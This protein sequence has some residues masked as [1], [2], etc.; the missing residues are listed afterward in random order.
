MFSCFI[1]F[2]LAHPFECKGVRMEGRVYFFSS[3]MRCTGACQ[4]IFF[5]FWQRWYL[6][7]RFVARIC[8]KNAKFSIFSIIEYV[9]L[10]FSFIK[11]L[12]KFSIFFQS[13]AI[14]GPF[15]KFRPASRALRG[16]FSN[17]GPLRGPFS[18]SGPLR[19]L[20]V[21]PVCRLRRQN[22]NS[23]LVSEVS[24]KKNIP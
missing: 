16:P 8:K 4:S 17:C 12:P 10:V 15:S 18:N 9:F 20:F 24:E 5:L 14:R 7:L 3:S 19:G 23:F 21:T 1:I 22:K 2:I 6:F 13:R 11:I